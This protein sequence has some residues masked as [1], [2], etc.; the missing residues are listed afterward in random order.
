M[1]PL[2]DFPLQVALTFALM[3]VAMGV[4]PLTLAWLWAR[5]FS[6]RKPGTDKS[7]AYEC[8]LQSDG[9][10]GGRQR[11]DY[12]LYAIV[13]LVFDVES[14]FLVPFAVA[15]SGLP[16][17]AVLAMGAFLLLLAEGLVWAW[18]K[19]VLEWH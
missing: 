17:G 5:T 2:R 18:L 13:F 15:Y 12:Y 19:G 9:D 7:A 3:A 8:G 4:G 16:L 6:P 1:E 11:V 14:I 10:P